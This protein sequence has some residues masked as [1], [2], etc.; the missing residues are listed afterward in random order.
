MSKLKKTTLFIE[1]MHCPSCDVLVEDEFGTCPSVTSVKANYH[2]QTVEVTHRGTLPVDQLNK[3]IGQFGYSI[4]K[5]SDKFK[6]E[7][8]GKRVFDAGAIA[9]LVFILYFF[10]QQL[11][12]IPRFSSSTELT[13]TSALILGLIASSSTCMAT[14]GSLFLMTLGAIGRQK[15][16]KRTV[17]FTAI[18]FT[19]G[20]VA[21]YAFF[22]FLTGLVGQTLNK[23]MQWGSA[24]NVVVATIMI[25]VGLDMAG[26]ISVSGL[27]G[28]GLRK[29]LFGYLERKLF[30]R[31]KQ[32]SFFL[33]AITFLLPCGFTQTVQAYGLSLANPWQSALLL[34]VFAIGTVP[35][36]LAVG[37]ASTWVKSSWYPMFLKFIGVIILFVGV[38]SMVNYAQLIGI[39]LP[40]YSSVTNQSIRYVPIENGI[41]IARMDAGSTGYTPNLFTVR[42][43][44]PVRWE[45]YGQNIY[46]CQGEI[47][48]PTIQVQKVLRIGKNVVEFT[49]DKEGIIAFSCTMGMFGGKFQVI[50]S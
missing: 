25:I 28:E 48:A 6:R 21:S 44:I 12:I 13:L 30:E 40:T 49:P 1:G 42:R 16:E 18:L 31:P 27:L 47:V 26:L 38:I 45:I 41:Q 10:A 3:K 36:I 17:I 43:G 9:L 23:T 34:T 2:T 24:I 35:A 7:S 14:S 4:Y 22:G 39:A 37:Y 29:R 15:S 11:H 32:T 46:G 20:R 33:G 50:G 19:G 5:S 8:I